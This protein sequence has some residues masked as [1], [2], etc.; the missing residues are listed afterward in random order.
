MPL[1]ITPYERQQLLYMQQAA[2]QNPDIASTIAPSFFGTL[3]GAQ[4]RF[5]TRRDTRQTGLQGLREMAM[6]LA[7]SGASEDAV[8]AAVGGQAETLPLMG[9]RYGGERRMG[10]LEEFVGGLYGEGPVSGLAPQDMRDQF[11]G[12]ID[13]EDRRA[14]DSIVN[15]QMGQGVPLDA[16]REQI[17][18]EFIAQ[19]YDEFSTSEA[20]NEAMTAY[21]RLIGGSVEEMR[22]LGAELRGQF[23][24]EGLTPGELSEFSGLPDD[25]FA[26]I[27]GTGSGE[28]GITDV[29]GFLA[30]LVNDPELYRSFL[31]ADPEQEQQ[32]GLS[33]AYGN[34]IQSLFSLFG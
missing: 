2:G 23:G 7:S 11:S 28:A 9:P 4:E 1:P 6:Q 21:E 3:E 34:P 22:G 16:I 5:D 24:N 18:R 33:G 10:A 31:S 15:E 12:V 20:L 27:V 8:A 26:G 14:I 32:A 13:D 17:R 30:Q 29:K 19:G 25:R